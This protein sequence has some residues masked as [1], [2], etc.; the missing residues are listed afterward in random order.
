MRNKDSVLYTT[1]RTGTVAESSDDD[2]DD[3]GDDSGC[4]S[5]IPTLA[6]KAAV[7]KQKKINDQ[8]RKVIRTK[9]GCYKSRVG[10]LLKR[11]ARD[12]ALLYAIERNSPVGVK[13]LLECGY[14]ANRCDNSSTPPLLEAVRRGYHKVVKAMLECPR[15]DV[16]AADFAGWTALHVAAM[17]NEPAIAEQLLVAKAN[18]CALGLSNRTPLHMAAIGDNC[19]TAILLLGK[20]EVDVN[21]RDEYGQTP[22]HLA[23]YYDNPAVA[24]VLLC[25]GN[26]NVNIVD[27]DGE[28]PAATAVRCAGYKK[29]ESNTKRVLDMWT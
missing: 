25:P 15:V 8:L 18:P 23:A 28:T 5:P 4:Y 21:A 6:E 26:A 14:E 19:Q 2:D 24:S 22:L 12:D 7:K 29:L 27:K 20:P 16:N 11:G 17:H 1:V 13:A 9:K 10:A 3:R